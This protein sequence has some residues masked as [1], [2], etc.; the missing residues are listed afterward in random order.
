MACSPYLVGGRR[1]QGVRAPTE[2]PPPDPNKLMDIESCIDD[3]HLAP[4]GNHIV[5]HRPSGQPEGQVRIQKRKEA[6]SDGALMLRRRGLEADEL[7]DH[8]QRLMP[9]LAPFLQP[10]SHYQG[11]VELDISRN[12]LQSLPANVKLLKHLKTLNISANQL[13]V[14]PREIYHLTQLEVLILSQNYL[15]AIPSE[16]PVHLPNLIT[17]RASA[18]RIRSID[19]NL[20][21]WQKLKHFQLG[22]VFGGNQL[23]RLP[24]EIADMPAL[25]ELDLTHNQLRELPIN[26]HIDT[27]VHLNVSDNQL[28]CLPKSIANCRRLRTLNVSKNHLAT[29]PADLV[30]LTQLEVFDVSE[31]LLCIMPADILNQMR[32]TMLLITGNPLTRPGHCGRPDAYTQ[33]IQEMSRRALPTTPH[34]HRDPSSSASSSSSTSTTTSASSSPEAGPLSPAQSPSSSTLT[35]TAEPGSPTPALPSPVASPVSSPSPRRLRR[36][37]TDE[38]HDASIDRELSYHARQL[39]IYG[40]RP[41]PP[42]RLS[43]TMMTPSPLSTEIQQEDSYFQEADASTTHMTSNGHYVVPSL[44]EIASRS[45]LRQQIPVPLNQLPQ[46][47]ARDL[48]R[49]NYVLCASCGQQ[50]VHE[51]VT[52]V[53]VKSYKGHPAVVHRVRFCSSTCWRRC[54]YEQKDQTMSRPQAPLARRVP[55]IPESTIH[56]IEDMVN[57]AGEQSS[58]AT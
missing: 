12:R 54:L 43:G 44:R 34:H 15:V 27:L 13:H 57:A 16:M 55:P 40:A 53:Q 48:S 19:C 58:S 45:A 23:S 31:N 5:N 46:H 49:P 33:V 18:N 17:L 9:P 10:E 39:N 37:W 7:A 29:L 56:W 41:S 20:G 42:Q 24:D 26:M 25:E 30:Q 22:S 3:P 50:L 32:S 6:R 2:A 51:W 36:R 14:V 52:S 4:L 47:L 11:L 38:D 1:L 21:L 8:L 28:G 35:G